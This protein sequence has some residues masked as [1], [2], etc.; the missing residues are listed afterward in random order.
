MRQSCTPNSHPTD[1]DRSGAYE[2]RTAV[3]GKERAL[4]NWMD[5]SQSSAAMC[6]PPLHPHRHRPVGHPL[7]ALMDGSH[8]STDTHTTALSCPDIHHTSRTDAPQ[9]M[10]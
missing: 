1:T 3:K 6:P 9:T 4:P 8:P 2:S 5:D 7:H 10:H